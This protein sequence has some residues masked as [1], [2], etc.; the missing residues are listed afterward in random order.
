MKV[1]KNNKRRK[2]L[3][4]ATRK[5]LE[6]INP[7]RKNLELFM[8]NLKPQIVLNRDAPTCYL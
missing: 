7:Y 4:S 6:K 3:I 2:L 1:L 8:F 5:I